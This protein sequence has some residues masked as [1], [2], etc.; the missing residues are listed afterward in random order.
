MVLN[1]EVLEW[2]AVNSGDLKVQD[3]KIKRC[4]TN[5]SSWRWFI[6]TFYSHESKS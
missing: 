5:D 4:G 6:K 1:R 3:T 2:D